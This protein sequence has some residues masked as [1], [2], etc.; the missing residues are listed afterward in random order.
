VASLFHQRRPPETSQPTTVED[1]RF[2][3]LAP[4]DHEAF[5]AVY[6]RHF[7]GI[8]GYCF[9]E[10]GSAERAEDAAQQVFAEVLGTLPRYQERGRFRSWLYAIAYHVVH[11]QFRADHHDG[12]LD[13]IDEMVDP[14]SS[15]EE[16]VL[17]ALDR[18]ALLE[19]IA[20]LPRDQRRVVELRV[21]GLKGREIAAELG[22]SHEAVRMLQHRALD[23]LASALMSPDQSRGGRHG[24]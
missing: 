12:S 20:R 16:Q 13:D 1:G 24:A 22:R 4:P 10:L 19:A 5:A 6:R 11:D 21:A 17:G 2:G 9:R 3:T 14:G 8:Y 15:P 23:H 18:R 7:A